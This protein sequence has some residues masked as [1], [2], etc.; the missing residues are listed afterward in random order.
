MRR[1]LVIN[2]YFYPDIASTGRYATDICSGLTRF[3]YDVYVIT[4]TP[5]YTIHSPDAPLSEILNGVKVYRVPLVHIKGR[6]TMKL[7]IKGYIKFLFGAWKKANELLKSN[8]FDFI[9]TF[10]NP[11]LVGLIGVLLSKRYRCE[12]I[13]VP[14]DIH[15]DILIATGWK[16]PRFFIKI[17]DILNKIIFGSAKKVIVLS[18]GMKRIIVDKKGVKEKKVYVIPLWGIPEIDVEANDKINEKTEG[19]VEVKSKEMLFLHS[20]NLGVLYTFDVILDAAKN[21]KKE[22]VKFLFIGDGIKRKYLTNR[23][24]NENIQN[25]KVLPFQPTEKFVQI[26]NCSDICLV[27]IGEGLE[28]LALPSKTFTYLSAGRPVISIMEPNADIARIITQNDC[29]WNVKDADEL[30][31][32]VKKILKNPKILK[33]KRKNAKRTYEEYFRKEKIIEKYVEVISQS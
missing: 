23:I 27:T 12:F 32:L 2:Q 7:R 11:P 3:G 26:L 18:E 30:A 20:G 9:L 15:P 21:L 22:P 6:D 13:Y 14:H 19:E 5:S 10:H 28:N 4:G 16:L 8:K 1:L 24:K 31:I 29:G 33:L 17:W 25:V